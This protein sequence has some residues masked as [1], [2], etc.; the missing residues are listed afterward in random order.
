MGFIELNISL[1]FWQTVAAIVCLVI[2]IAG[3]FI[4]IK[5]MSEG[6]GG[7]LDLSGPFGC[8]VIFITLLVVAV[9]GGIFFW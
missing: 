9:I 3:L 2:L 8:L 1:T 5:L 4:G 7:F 6:G